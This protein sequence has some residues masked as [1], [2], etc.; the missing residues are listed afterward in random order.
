MDDGGCPTEFVAELAC[1][2]DACQG[3]LAGEVLPENVTEL[4]GKNGSIVCIAWDEGGEKRDPF[5]M[6][7]PPMICGFGCSFDEFTS[8]LGVRQQCQAHS[9]V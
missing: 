9:A 4:C 6:K 3:V 2:L 8:L 1:V 5:L 7:L